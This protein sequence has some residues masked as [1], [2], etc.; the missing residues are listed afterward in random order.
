MKL[1]NLNK[2]AFIIFSG[3]G[4][5]ALNILDQSSDKS[6]ISKYTGKILKNV[7]DASEEIDIKIVSSEFEKEATCLGGIFMQSS[8]DAEPQQ[9]VYVGQ[10]KFAGFNDC[11]KLKY[12][13]IDESIKKEIIKNINGFLKMFF[14]EIGDL[15][16][17]NKLGIKINQ[18]DIR[19]FIKNN[20]ENYLEEGLD[21]RL[22]S[23]KLEEEIN[24]T[25]F[26]Y[27]VIKIISEL[28]N[29]LYE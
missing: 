15:N 8:S 19:K 1:A 10:H 7:F 5:R 29:N 14:D 4:S 25:L 26:F 17:E 6:F 23:V 13:Q 24:E 11:N 18:E 12:G 28:C 20:L 3:R 2:P 16:I 9:L 21:Y 22:Q 27:P